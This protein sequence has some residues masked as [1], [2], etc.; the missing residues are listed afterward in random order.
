MQVLERG[1][2]GPGPAGLGRSTDRGRV[3]SSHGAGESGVGGLAALRPGS[4]LTGL[5]A[6]A[7]CWGALSAA[8][9]SWSTTRS[10]WST[11][12]PQR[13]STWSSRAAP[14][15]AQRGL[16]IADA[17]SFGEDWTGDARRPMPGAGLARGGRRGGRTSSALAPLS[18]SVSAPLCLQICPP[19]FT[20]GSEMGGVWRT[21]RL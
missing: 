3:S 17:A 15:P 21:A 16:G 6:A 14:A 11:P 13:T 5:R 9:P 7:E 2:R 19:L 4:K 20:L 10:T 1:G 12:A 18:A 8:A